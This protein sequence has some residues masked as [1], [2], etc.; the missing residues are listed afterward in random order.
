[1]TSRPGLLIAGALV[2]SVVVGCSVSAPVEPPPPGW[3]QAEA[4]P[5]AAGQVRPVA[6]RID[7]IGLS[8]REWLEV[9]QDERGAVEVPDVKTPEV[10]GVYCPA[11]RWTL[12]AT[13]DD[14]DC[15]APVPG[16]AGNA[17]V[18]AHNQGSGK[19]GAFYRLHQVNLGALVEVDRS[20]G[21][22][23]VFKV[24][25]V[26]TVPK[27]QFPTDAVFNDDTPGQRL[28][29]ITCG[30]DWDLKNHRS[31]DQVIV[32]SELVTLRPTQLTTPAK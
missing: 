8:G 10:L 25:R 6:L 4:P 30:Q 7:S 13:P 16:E 23:A 17:V 28:V 15:G 22:T 14:P 1:M 32:F 19:Q 27:T 2:A 29:M 11:W 9:G 21:Q 26:R 18:L 24:T 20:D 31:R 5:A 3:G 12:Q